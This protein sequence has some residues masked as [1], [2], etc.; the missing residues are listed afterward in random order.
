MQMTTVRAARLL[1]TT[2]ITVAAALGCASQNE[3][4]PSGGSRSDASL[5]GALGQCG[6]YCPGQGTAKG[7]CIQ[8]TGQCGLDYGLGCVSK[9][10]TYG[11]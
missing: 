10:T 7:C 3:S 2:A 8:S 6:A 9:T 5:D 4:F 11:P 1:V